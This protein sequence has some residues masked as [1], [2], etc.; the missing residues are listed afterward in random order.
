[1]STRYL[2]HSRYKRYL[3]HRT[4]ANAKLSLD[5]IK[6]EGSVG[7]TVNLVVTTTPPNLPIRAAIDTPTTAR[8]TVSGNVVSVHLLAQDATTMVVS[9]ANGQLSQ[10]VMVV[11][12][13]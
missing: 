5:K 6:I 2:R 10:E 9:L 7:Q 11:V 4:F 1:M 13:A 8:I 12:S 3:R